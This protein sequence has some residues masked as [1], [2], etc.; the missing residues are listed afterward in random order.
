MKKHHFLKLVLS[1][2]LFVVFIQA[3]FAQ[4]TVTVDNNAAGTLATYTFTYVTA[5]GC[6]AIN[7]APNIFLLENQT[8]FPNFVPYSP[9]PVFA[10]LAILKIN[11]V[12]TPINATNFGNIYGSWTNGIQISTGNGTTPLVI[13]AGSTI[14]LIISGV[15]TNPSTPQNYTMNWKIADAS[16]LVRE[17]FATP[18]TIAA[19]NTVLGTQKINNNSVSLHP[20]PFSNTININ[21][22]DSYNNDNLYVQIT[23]ITGRIIHN[24]KHSV[25]NNSVTIANLDSYTSGSYFVKVLDENQNLILTKQL[26]KN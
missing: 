17:S 7:S 16:G 15:I 25:I 20:N 22:S 3:S 24:E 13:T 18:L 14:Q 6:G 21:I 5:N 19:T 12:V 2:T 1:M 4:P 10:P 9:L 26:L 23:D 8:G 11:G